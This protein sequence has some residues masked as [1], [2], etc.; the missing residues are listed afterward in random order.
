MGSWTVLV[1]FLFSV[2]N[3]PCDRGQLALE[4]GRARVIQHRFAVC[5]SF[6]SSSS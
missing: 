5:F 6:F 2:Q 1:L 3:K 4:D